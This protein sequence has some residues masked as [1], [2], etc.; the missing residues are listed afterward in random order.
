V[1]CRVPQVATKSCYTTLLVHER[2]PGDWGNKAA[3]Q[4][5]ILFCN[6]HAGVVGDAGGFLYVITFAFLTALVIGMFWISNTFIIIISII[7]AVLFSAY[8]LYDIQVS[9]PL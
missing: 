2:L 5:S 7:G 3:V 9:V 6:H 4:S 1:G 8:L